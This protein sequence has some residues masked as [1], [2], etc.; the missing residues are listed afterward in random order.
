MPQ[1]RAGAN[2]RLGVYHRIYR[3]ME[4]FGEDDCLGGFEPGL[5]RQPKPL[6]LGWAVQPIVGIV[7][8]EPRN[9]S[10]QR[11]SPRPVARQDQNLKGEARS[12]NAR[13]DSLLDPPKQRTG[14]SLPPE[15]SFFITQ[16]M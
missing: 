8:C 12:S 6:A 3:A 9:Q 10:F 15:T 16:S 5:G 1:P 11:T 2:E 13:S 4:R 14:Q 7:G